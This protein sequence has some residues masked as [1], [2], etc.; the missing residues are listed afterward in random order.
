MP[1]LVYDQVGFD[2]A[3]ARA[4]VKEL[5]R[6]GAEGLRRFVSSTNPGLRDVTPPHIMAPA[7]GLESLPY[8]RSRP[9]DGPEAAGG[10]VTADLPGG[11]RR[12]TRVRAARNE[13]PWPVAEE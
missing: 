5:K 4:R 11:P 8:P 10:G 12:P 6:L 7:S 2:V 9:G 1:K 3:G 13:E